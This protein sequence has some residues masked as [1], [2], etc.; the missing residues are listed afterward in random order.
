MSGG[1]M[2]ADAFV[3][4]GDKL[5]KN[6]NQTYAMVASAKS[7]VEKNKLLFAQLEESKKQYGLDYALKRLMGMSQISATEKQSLMMELTGRSKAQSTFAD[8]QI[9]NKGFRDDLAAQKRRNSVGKG[10]AMGFAK[11][12]QGN[13]RPAATGRTSLLP[14]AT[15]Q[16]TQ[17][18]TPQATQQSGALL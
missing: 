10:F 4:L 7:D 18:A 11:A 16:A 9:K 1:G 13:S 17:R 3:N 15:Q 8:T 12:M 6:F 2:M 14:Q 5:H